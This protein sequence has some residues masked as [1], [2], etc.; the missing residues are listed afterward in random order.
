MAERIGCHWHIAKSKGLLQKRRGAC[1]T[2][3]PSLHEHLSETDPGQPLARALLGSS[4]HV[5]A[6]E[7]YITPRSSAA[8][9]TFNQNLQVRSLGRRPEGHAVPRNGWWSTCAFCAIN[10]FS[11]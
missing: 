4:D 5:V 11:L 2:G 9:L 7:E 3:R 1:P 10:V 6:V 8:Y